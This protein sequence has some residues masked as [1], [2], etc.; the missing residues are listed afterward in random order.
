MNRSGLAVNYWIKKTGIPTENLLVFTDD[1]SLPFGAI[2][3]RPKGGDGGHNGLTSINQ[4]LG[5]QNYARV[6]FGIGSE[7]YPGQQVDYVLS[8]WTVEEHKVLQQRLEVCS[9]L[10]KSYGTIGLELT[11]T[12]F[13]SK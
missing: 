13:N 10:I 8:E 7:F 11:M 9:E 4:V 5:T 1:I 3:I 6:R 12:R 2:R